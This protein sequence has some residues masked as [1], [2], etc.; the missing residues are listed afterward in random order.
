MS[1]QPT[2]NLAPRNERRPSP[3]EAPPRPPP[4]KPREEEP[5]AAQHPAPPP[6]CDRSRRDRRHRGDRWRAGSG[7]CRRAITRA[8]TTPSSTVGRCT[9]T[10]RSSGVIEEVPVTDNQIVKPG[11]LLVRIDRRDYQAAVDSAQAQIEQAA[12]AVANAN[13]QIYEQAAN[14]EQVGRQVV[15]AQAALDFSR[16]EN[17]RYQTL[18]KTGAG[19]VQRAQQSESDLLSRQAAVSAAQFAQASAERQTRGARCPAQERRGAAR[20]REGAKGQSRCRIS[21][22]PNYMRRRRAASRS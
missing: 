13:A 8:R 5:R 7:I 4:V 17:T 10:S 6:H 18:V 3:P 9:S 11:D 21:V 2:A 15:E 19:T 12:A 22:A 14:I 20:G 16:E 1:Q